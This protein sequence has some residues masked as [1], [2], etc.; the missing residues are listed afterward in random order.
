MKKWNAVS[1]KQRSCRYCYMDSLHG[2]WQNGY[3]YKCYTSV[4]LGKGRMHPFIHISIGYNLKIFFVSSIIFQQAKAHIFGR[5]WFF[6]M[7]DYFLFAQSQIVFKHRYFKLMILCN[8][9][10][11]FAHSKCLQELLFIVCL[12]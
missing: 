9:N 4:V 7:Y 2:R 1:F 5:Q 12:Q 6:F 11:L 10:H 3:I 8:I